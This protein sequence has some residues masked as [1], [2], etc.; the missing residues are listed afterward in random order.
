MNAI[1]PIAKS[2]A[3]DWGNDHEV[4]G[5]QGAVMVISE[6]CRDTYG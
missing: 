3:K 1:T 2:T 4:A 5:A 6:R